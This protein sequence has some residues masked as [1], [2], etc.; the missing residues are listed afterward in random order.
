MKANLLLH[1][2][3]FLDTKQKTPLSKAVLQEWFFTP[4]FRHCEASPLYRSTRSMN[5]NANCIY[6]LAISFLIAVWLVG[7][8][9]FSVNVLASY[10]GVITSSGRSSN[11]PPTLPTNWGE[12]LTHYMCYLFIWRH[13]ATYFLFIFHVTMP[14]VEVHPHHPQLCSLSACLTVGYATMLFV[15][16]SFS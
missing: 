10:F 6:I 11:H 15:S 14:V 7:K 8:S 3:P 4:P 13:S 9:T 12:N 5:F 2:R 1:R 16:W